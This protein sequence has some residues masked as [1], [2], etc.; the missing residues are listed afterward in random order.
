MP[1]GGVGGTI[2]SFMN[3]SRQNPISPIRGVSYLPVSPFPTEYGNDGSMTL[4]RCAEYA[5]SLVR[6]ARATGRTPRPQE[7]NIIRH[8]LATRRPVT[9]SGYAGLGRTMA[10]YQEGLNELE[11]LITG[12]TV[13]SIATRNAAGL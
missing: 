10:K 7:L 5:A 12:E 2:N 4:R 3:P 1:F 13:D 9:L 8:Y 6:E 11:S